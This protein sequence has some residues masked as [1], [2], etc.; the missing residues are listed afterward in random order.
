M[1]RDGLENHSTVVELV[2]GLTGQS[3]RKLAV[4]PADALTD[5][6]ARGKSREE[7]DR[8]S[9]QPLRPV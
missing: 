5:A 7:A 6:Q 4:V 9:C 8:T 1:W 3:E 2:V